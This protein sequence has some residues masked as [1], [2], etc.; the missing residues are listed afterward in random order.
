[1]LERIALFLFFYFADQVY[2]FLDNQL[3][4]MS[5]DGLDPGS[6]F[7][8]VIYSINAKGKGELLSISAVT[9]QDQAEKRTG[10]FNQFLFVSNFILPTEFQKATLPLLAKTVRLR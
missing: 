9:I 7:A 10:Y 5:A 6:T 2:N 4:N 1:M 8:G 3:P